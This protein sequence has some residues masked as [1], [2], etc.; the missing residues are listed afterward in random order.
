[1]SDVCMNYIENF[2]SQNYYLRNDLK[3]IIRKSYP[4]ID[5]TTYHLA[6]T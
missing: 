6:H 3:L 1:M 5:Y 4:S 2:I